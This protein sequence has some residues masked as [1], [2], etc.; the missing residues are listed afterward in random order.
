[1]KQQSNC[2]KRY[3]LSTVLILSSAVTYCQEITVPWSVDLNNTVVQITVRHPKVSR[4]A[5]G[6]LAKYKDKG[7]LITVKHA[8][9]G[10]EFGQLVEL[11]VNNGDKGIKS[12]LPAYFDPSVG[13][14]DI[15]VLPLPE[16]VNMDGFFEIRDSVETNIGDPIIFI[17]YPSTLI[18]G[19]SYGIS[20]VTETGKI[21]PLVKRGYIS[22]YN[23]INTSNSII[24][25]DTQS[26]SGFSGS[27]VFVWDRKRKSVQILGV[28]AGGY[29]A[30]VH[31]ISG[32]VE[33]TYNDVFYLTSLSFGNGIGYAIDIID[34]YILRGVRP[35]ND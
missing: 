5:T 25:Y 14:S 6:F 3:L 24:I 2:M 4:L 19:S 12:K 8:L 21:S 26:V 30:N 31:T 7:Y 32:D 33:L 27:P 11:E 13:S 29:K 23:A 10:F 18:L 20:T 35:L 9:D 34:Y 22:G 15:A 16:T 28:M 17:G 1:M